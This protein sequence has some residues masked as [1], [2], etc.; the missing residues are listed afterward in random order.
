ARE[1]LVAH[2]GARRA[3]STRDRRSSHARLA[4]IVLAAA[5]FALGGLAAAPA[6]AAAAGASVVVVVGPVG[7]QTARYIS[8]ARE[9]AEEA[10]SFGANVSEIYSPNATWSRVVSAA[11]GANVLIYLGHGNGWPSPYGPFSAERKDGLGLNARAGEGNS[12]TTYYGESRIAESIRLAPNAVVILN[13]LC[14]ASGNSE[15]GNADPSRSVAMR[16]VDNYGAGFLRAGAAA[17]IADGH[18]DASYVLRGLFGTNL[19]L[20]EIFWNA[21]WSST[22]QY[23]IEFASTRTRG[24]RAIMDPAHPGGY[25]RSIVGRLGVTA[26]EWR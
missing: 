9:L 13:H 24:A 7:S 25:Y 5:A 11:R 23:T 26:V 17:V 3:S 22:G 10:R 19:S 1:L 8:I 12:E 16:R 21:G 6:P 20:E 4:A 15:P 2:R 14:Y 18:G